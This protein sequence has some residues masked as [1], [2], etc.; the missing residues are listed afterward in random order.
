MNSTDDALK[1]AVMQVAQ[2]KVAEALGGDILGTMVEAVMKHKD[3]SYGRRDDKT[4]F[5]RLVESHIHHVL[6]EAI[7]EHLAEHSA[8]IK[9]AVAAAMAREGV[10]KFATT[11]VDAFQSEDWRAELKV[12]V[13]RR[14]RD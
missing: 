7:R 2:A 8:A 9:A 14:G 6:S 13:E 3:S 10:E 5:E 1:A 12:N 11:I 4:E